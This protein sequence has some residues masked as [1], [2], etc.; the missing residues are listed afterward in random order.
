[1]QVNFSMNAPSYIDSANETAILSLA[2][3]EVR[4]FTFDM[5]N[6]IFSNYT[7]MAKVVGL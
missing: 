7:Q 6:A 5:D 2:D 4:S 3:A 1:M